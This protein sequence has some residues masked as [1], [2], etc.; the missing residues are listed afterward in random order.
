M[1][2]LDGRESNFDLEE[3]LRI[4]AVNRFFRNDLYRVVLT[5]V[6]LYFLI[7]YV[8]YG[9]WIGLAILAGMALAN[10]EIT[11]RI[12]KFIRIIAGVEP[13]G[14]GVINESL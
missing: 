12:A 3:D 6:G 8:K 1:T 2:S 4:A 7:R 11:D 5:L 13:A 9:L 10:N 14:G